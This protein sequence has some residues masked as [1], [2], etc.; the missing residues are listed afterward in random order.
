MQQYELKTS[1]KNNSSSLGVQSGKSALPF[2][3]NRESSLARQKK[4]ANEFNSPTNESE[5]NVTSTNR[6]TSTIQKKVNNNAFIGNSIVQRVLSETDTETFHK[7]L[8]ENDIKLHESIIE[9]VVKESSNIEEAKQTVHIE[10]ESLKQ[11]GKRLPN[12]N[13]TM[14]S[15]SI[16]KEDREMLQQLLNDLSSV[17]LGTALPQ[18]TASLAE[19]LLAQY[20]P[21]RFTYIMM[22]NSPAP[23]MAF[24]QIKRVRSFH[25]PLG[26]I[27]DV[28]QSAKG[29]VDN[30]A[31]SQELINSYF[32]RTLGEA[33][34]TGKPLVL[35][36]Y[37]SSGSSM[38]MAMDLIKSWLAAR[39]K[40]IP[41]AFFGFT[42]HSPEELPDLMQ[43]NHAGMLA[44][45]TGKMEK[46]FIKMMRRKDYK[47]VFLLKGP[48][49]MEM[50]KLLNTGNPT[51]A[52]IKHVEYY[53][54]LVKMM[55]AEF[56]K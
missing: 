4:T 31:K 28:A 24:L 20:P 35:I 51:E 12:V 10:V 55:I 14:G 47:N 7:W 37:V 5:F 6:S 33:A 9:R 34:D 44:T 2:I 26:G 32:D 50:S 43:G 8:D 38:I 21:D 56:E 53:E 30:V 52:M 25:L 16:T 49:S 54:R 42:D 27:T 1:I 3:D 22:G 40:A 11:K 48:A 13:K 46:L 36:D 18:A 41:V 17:G 23:L 45:A 39:K 19:V 29:F 15:K